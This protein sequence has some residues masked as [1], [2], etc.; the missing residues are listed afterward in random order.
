MS[1]MPSQSS[2]EIVGGGT[3]GLVKLL[4]G[5]AYVEKTPHEDSRHMFDDD[6][7][8][9]YLVYRTLPRH[10][11]ILSLHADSSPSRIVLPYL[12]N[13]TLKDLLQDVSISQSQRIQLAADAAEG[14][15]VLH[16]A[17]VIHCDLNVFNFMVDDHMR[18]RIIDF[19]GSMIDG[20]VGSGC[21]GAPYFLP[22]DFEQPSTVTSDIL[23]LGSVIY[24]IATGNVPYVGRNDD[25]I[26]GLF[27]KHKFPCTEHLELGTIVLKCWRQ[28]YQLAHQVLED[29][30]ALQITIPEPKA[31][32]SPRN[33]PMA[34]QEQSDQ[35]QITTMSENYLQVCNPIPSFCVPHQVRACDALP[36]FARRNPSDYPPLRTHAAQRSGIVRA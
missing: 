24:A 20:Q 2:A 36:L 8:R 16:D 19:A 29:I 18:L 31:R 13:G 25:E 23:A 34:R 12:R 9:E 17:G 32:R 15:Q 5:G 1:K 28:G 35:T 27:R 10:E 33:L 3:S 30:R 4:S 14:L 26:E 22:R 21:E 6:L 7:A 11:R